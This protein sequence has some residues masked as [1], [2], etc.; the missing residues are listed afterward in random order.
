[1]YNIYAPKYSQCYAIVPVCKSDFCTYGDCPSI[2]CV[3]VVYTCCDV[4][5]HRN[6]REIMGRA[7]RALLK[8]CHQNADTWATSRAL[9]AS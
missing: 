3:Y 1:M 5:M 2:L 8:L 4:L 6:F 9:C 7:A